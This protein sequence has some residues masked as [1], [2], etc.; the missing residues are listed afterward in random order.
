MQRNQ[1]V[2]NDE[3][4]V[5][6]KSLQWEK[7]GKRQVIKNARTEKEAEAASNNGTRRRCTQ[8][9]REAVKNDLSRKYNNLERGGRG[10]RERKS[11]ARSGN[12]RLR[13]QVCIRLIRGGERDK[14]PEALLGKPN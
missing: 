5:T 14:P 13:L 1:V 4:L 2:K 12:S 9:L 10:E 3:V 7:K 6:G 11:P 8:E